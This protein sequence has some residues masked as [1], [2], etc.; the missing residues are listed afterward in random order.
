MITTL[1]TILSIAI[2]ELMLS[3]D[4]ALVNASLAEELPKKLQKRAIYLGIALGALFRVLCLFMAT[5]IIEN[6]G[7]KIAGAL[8]LIWLG[9]S[10]FFRTKK[11]EYEL[12]RHPHFHLVIGQ[13]ALADL[14]F[15]IDN[16]VGAVGIS[17]EFGY[18]VFGVL[19]GI[20]TMIFV[21]PLMLRLMNTFPSLIKTAYAIITYV[22]FIILVE[23]F[24]HIHVPEYLTFALIISAILWTMHAD[25]KRGAVTTH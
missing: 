7:F 11:E 9:Y 3:V 19:I 20:T 22:G 23:T 2:L 18:V 4:N 15:S 17:S 25:K 24:T 14:V 16:V 5:L 10:H 12:R 6:P 1:S 8:Y 21:T 13:I